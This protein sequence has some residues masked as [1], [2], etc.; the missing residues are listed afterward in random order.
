MSR[1]TVCI[2]VHIYVNGNSDS[3]IKHLDHCFCSC[4]A[5]ACTRIIMS[6]TCS[7]VHVLWLY[8]LGHF[9]LVGAVVV[10][11]CVRVAVLDAGYQPG[12]VGH[13]VAK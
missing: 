11:E 5:Y 2:H 13:E 6:S 1:C 3:Q 4:A 10:K 12:Q 9:A 8:L 7:Y